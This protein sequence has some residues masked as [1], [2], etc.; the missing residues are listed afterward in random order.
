MTPK[1]KILLLALALLCAVDGGARTRKALYVIIDGIPA[2][3]LERLQPPTI[4]EIAKAGG[5]SRGYCGG[6]VGRYS[7][8]PTI[9]AIGYSNI[10]TGTWMNKH[11][12]RGNSDIHPNY[13]YPTIFRI[14]K[15]QPGRDVKTAIYSSWSDN[16]TILLGEGK[17]ETRG[18]KIDYVVDGFDL[19][20]EKYPNKPGEL[21]VFDYDAEVAKGAAQCIRANAPDLNWLYLWYS[22]DAYH[23]N[24]NGHI[25]DWG[26]MAEDSLLRPVWEAVKERQKNHDEDWLVIVTTD[27]GRM[28]NGTHHGGQS[29]TERTIWISTNLKKRNGEFGRETLSHVDILPTICKWM[30]FKL[31]REVSFELDGTPF[32]GPEDIHGLWLDPWEKYATLHW[33][34]NGKDVPVEIWC[35][36]TNDFATGGKDNWVKLATVSSRK[37]QYTTTD[38]KIYDC[39]VAK[40]AVVTPHTTLTTW[41]KQ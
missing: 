35:T 14:A 7:E 11:N 21:Q 28:Y 9:S 34:N 24:G 20:H 3:A 16:R 12:V 37:E 40:F 30:D 15:D 25:A 32:Y 38:P 27:H 13:N 22:D 19:D 10:N 33:K 5:Y 36:T 4:M 18:L 39:A 41:W 26:V 1:N 6:T 29:P 23:L 31:P 17:P 8:T 2:S